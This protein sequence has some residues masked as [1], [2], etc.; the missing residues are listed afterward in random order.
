MGLLLF[1]QVP[2]PRTS[3]ASSGRQTH[4]RYVSTQLTLPLKGARPAAIRCP[5][6]SAVQSISSPPC[7]RADSMC[8]C[9]TSIVGIGTL[10][11][12]ASWRMWLRISDRPSYASC[13]CHEQSNP[14]SPR[15]SDAPAKVEPALRVKLVVDDP[16]RVA[17]KR[18]RLML[19]LDELY[20]LV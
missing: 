9:A 3:R 10:L 20:K 14:D 16:V 13:C 4:L 15:I 1:A 7:A 18:R 2:I 19:V 12:S 6:T 17:Y 5:P 11:L 8:W